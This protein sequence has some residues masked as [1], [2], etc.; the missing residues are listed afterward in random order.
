MIP[1]WRFFLVIFSPLKFFS[2]PWIP[3]V[4]DGC[5]HIWRQF[6]DTLH[7][8]CCLNFRQY[9][10]FLVCSIEVA[11]RKRGT[12]SVMDGCDLINRFKTVC[13]IY[14]AAQSHS[15]FWIILEKRFKT[16]S[17]RLLKKT[18]TTKV[19]L[20]SSSSSAVLAYYLS[21]HS[22]PRQSPE[23]S[24]KSHCRNDTWMTLKRGGRFTALIGNGCLSF[25]V[26]FLQLCIIQS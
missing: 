14:A 25:L 22:A 10:P 3:T 7:W 5:I 2:E 9:R 24:N 8:I 23:M 6:D 17:Q 21:P 20:S 11:V 19:N 26:V 12:R 13:P 15:K 18:P 1:G 4:W 16:F